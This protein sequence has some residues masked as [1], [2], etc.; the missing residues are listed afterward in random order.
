MMYRWLTLATIVAHELTIVFTQTLTKQNV[1][2]RR[3]EL[4][5]C[6]ILQ[7]CVLVALQQN[8]ASMLHTKCKALSVAD[9]K[10]LHTGHLH[11]ATYALTN[12][13]QGI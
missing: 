10:Q 11:G 8:P 9:G 4:K 5:P 3:K 13:L 2:S 6:A 1:H 7:A 12:E